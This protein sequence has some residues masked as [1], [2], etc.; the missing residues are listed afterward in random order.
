MGGLSSSLVDLIHH[1]GYAGL[2]VVMALGNM[3]MPVGTEIVLPTA[4]ALAAQGHLS[5]WVVVALVATLGEVV[6]G[7]I[8]YL[9][10]YYGGEPFV[11]RYGKYVFFREHE[12]ARVHGFYARYGKKTVFI[13]R[14]VPFVRGVAAFPAGLSRMPKRYFITYTLA[15]SAIFCFALAYLGQA[16]GQNLDT[17]LPAIHRF[18][19]VIAAAVLVA[20]V[21]VVWLKMVRR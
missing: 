17:V 10:G 20:I 14:F 1:A 3:G 12:L 2:F 18:S 16:L 19:L 8:L 5:S 9:V 7:F 13:C 11:H 6:G 15:G 4:G 21:M